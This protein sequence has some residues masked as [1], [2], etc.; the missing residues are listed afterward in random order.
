MNDGEMSGSV[1]AGAPSLQRD[2]QT[3]GADRVVLAL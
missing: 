3:G 2:N 1:V